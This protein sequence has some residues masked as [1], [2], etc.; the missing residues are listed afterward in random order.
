MSIKTA[1]G[2]VLRRGPVKFAG[3][4]DEGLDFDDLYARF[5]KHAPRCPVYSKALS[6]RHFDA[7]GTKTCQIMTEGRYNDLLTP[8]EHYIPVSTDLSNVADAITQFKDEG[9]RERIATSALEHAMALH[10]YR[11]RMEF[12]RDCLYSL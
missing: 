9:E 10:T 8:N 4:E 12:L 7:I 5:F 6:S 11:H 3:F 1:L 2:F